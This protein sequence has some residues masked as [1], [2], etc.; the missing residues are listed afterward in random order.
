MR[1]STKPVVALDID[2]TLGDYH[3]HFTR[4]AEQ[5]CGRAM[6]DPSLNTD[7]VPLYKWLGMS[8]ATYRQCKLAYRQGG[9]KRSMPAYDG[10]S[11]LTRTLRKEGAEVWIATTRPY[12]RLDNIDP[13]TRHWLRRNKIQFDGVLFGEHKYRDLNRILGERVLFVVDDLPEMIEQAL[14]LGMR[15]MLR[16]QPY[17]EYFQR[18]GNWGRVGSCDDMLAIFRDEMQRSK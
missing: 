4:F 17:N 9:L 1:Y 14:G 16:R 3:G 6:P 13:D 8:K 11:E 5:W 2:G 15:A 18:S 7:G 10:A 12:L